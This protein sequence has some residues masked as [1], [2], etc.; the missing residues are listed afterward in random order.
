MTELNH[1]LVTT[2]P[3]HVRK[4]DGTDGI[5]E[6]CDERDCTVI[7]QGETGSF[8][9]EY[10]FLCDECYKET[11]ESVGSC[12]WCGRYAMLSPIRAMDEGLAGPVY[13]VCK[14]CQDMEAKRLEKERKYT[15][16]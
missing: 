8:G 4:S 14:T 5:C 2:L 13:D 12:D 1:G 16:M 7:L 15:E 6:K 11:T 10:G 3:G 9:R